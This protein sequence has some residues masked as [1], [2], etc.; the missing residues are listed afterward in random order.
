MN[1]TVICIGREY[2]SGGREIGEKLAEHLGVICY[3]KL[4]LQ[5]AAEAAGLSMTA[6]ENSDEKP[7]GLGSM[8]PCN[9]FANSTAIS[10]AFYSERQVVF[11]AQ[12]KAILNIAANGPCVI[13]GRCAS[14]I[15]RSAGIDVKSVF[16]YADDADKIHRISERNGIGAKEAEKKMI[17]VNRMRKKYF[18]FYADTPWGS[19][20]S[21][22]IMISSSRYGVDGSVALIEDAL[23]LAV[24]K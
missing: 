14:S 19:P 3:D 17:K 24:R 12:R 22:D 9:V 7:I 21:Y 13:I 20:H 1:N 10:T 6:V 15:L 16:I 8:V 2:G 11:D 23:K 4:L 18:D 5:H